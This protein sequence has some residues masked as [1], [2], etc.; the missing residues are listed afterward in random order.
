MLQSA[1]KC[2]HQSLGVNECEYMGGVSVWLLERF[3]GQFISVRG[4]CGDNRGN[5]RFYSPREDAVSACLCL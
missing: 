4:R 3:D 2:I 5:D 1:A